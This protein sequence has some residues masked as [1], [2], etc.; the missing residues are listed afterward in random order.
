MT[1]R[2]TTRDHNINVLNE[3][4]Y[5]KFK[6]TTL[7][8]NGENTLISPSVSEGSNGKYWFDLREVN[9]NQLSNN[10]YIVIRIVPDL[11]IVER[12]THIAPLL[13]KEAKQNRPHSGNVWAVFIEFNIH[14]NFAYLHNGK[15]FINKIKCNLLKKKD[16]INLNQRL[17]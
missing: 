11:F 2:M 10:S 4:G 17:Q 14:D 13:T 7:F 6:N 12:I 1:N 3:I 16:I 15:K 9:L 8:K 5:E